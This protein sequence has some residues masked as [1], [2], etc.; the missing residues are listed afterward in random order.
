MKT[1]LESQNFLTLDG[2]RGVGAI[3]VV[4]GHSAMFWPGF[5]TLPLVPLVDIFFI[6]SGFVLAFASDG[7]G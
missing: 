7:V 6:L 1:R 2:G 3:L 4:L 5:P